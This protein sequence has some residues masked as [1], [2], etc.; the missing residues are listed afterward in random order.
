MGLG[1]YLRWVWPFAHAI[2]VSLCVRVCLGKWCEPDRG[3]FL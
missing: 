3:V 2:V 1:G